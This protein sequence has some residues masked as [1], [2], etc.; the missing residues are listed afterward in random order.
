M[1]QQ[2]FGWQVQ[3][4]VQLGASLTR[5]QNHLWGPLNE[6]GDGS[7]T[8]LMFVQSDSRMGQGGDFPT[9]TSAKPAGHITVIT[10][11]PI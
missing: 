4:P 11:P 10:T 1:R 8:L 5:C 7:P 3:A 9:L 2:G 6:T